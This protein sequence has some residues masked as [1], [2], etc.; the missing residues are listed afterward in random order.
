MK[1]ISAISITLNTFIL[2]LFSIIQNFS[3]ISPY[4]LC[5]YIHDDL[6]FFLFKRFLLFTLLFVLL[7]ILNLFLKFIFKVLKIEKVIITKKMCLIIFG[8]LFISFLLN[9]FNILNYNCINI[10]E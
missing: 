2:I 10:Q 9:V 3:N 5:Q 1:K 8:I 6:Y 4:R 7:I